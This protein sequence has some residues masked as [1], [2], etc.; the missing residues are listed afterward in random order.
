MSLQPRTDPIGGP[1]LAIGDR[2]YVLIY[3]PRVIR[4]RSI[5]R[6]LVTAGAA[7][8][9]VGSFVPWVSSGA[10]RR[11]S[12]DLFDIVERLGFAPDGAFALIVRVWWLLPLALV[13]ATV[14]VWYGR[15]WT[16][17]AVGGGAALLA[18]AVGVGVL[19]ADENAFVRV[20]GGPLVAL[21]GAAVLA[22]G[23]ATCAAVASG[24]F[25]RGLREPLHP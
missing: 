2:R 10:K 21:A 16:S 18:A 24:R 9:L 13:V 23:A 20:L 7:V 3:P 25:D 11:S 1:V 6:G 15:W 22:A 19:S 5:A 8:V 14:A 4:A 17:A 12:Y